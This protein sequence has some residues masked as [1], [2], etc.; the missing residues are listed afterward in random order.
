MPQT[1]FNH[2]HNIC[3]SLGTTKCSNLSTTTCST[4]GTSIQRNSRFLKY[5]GISYLFL[6]LRLWE[7]YKKN[8]R[9]SSKG[10]S[11][12][13]VF[14]WSYRKPIY[15]TYMSSQ[16]LLRQRCKGRSTNKVGDHNRNCYNSE[17]KGIVNDMVKILDKYLHNH[18]KYKE[19]KD[20]LEACYIKSD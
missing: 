2:W 1:M 15:K 20:T 4:A 19:M 13:H 12:H 16:G 18:P 9:Q 7:P 17:I 10:S 11:S 6:R 14:K 8:N 3:S 5:H